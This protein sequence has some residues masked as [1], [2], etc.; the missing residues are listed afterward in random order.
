MQA[1]P[2]KEKR[3][4]RQ[5]HRYDSISLSGDKSG[6]SNR[7]MGT[8]ECLFVLLSFSLKMV[9]CAFTE[10]LLS[11]V[12][13]LSQ[14]I[15][16]MQQRMLELKKTLQK[17]LVSVLPSLLPVPSGVLWDPLLLDDASLSPPSH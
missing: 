9:K 17:E 14:A 5:V 6:T 4:W 7:C 3:P 12:G 15:K 16:Q 11:G 10:R 13:D 1:A 2:C 8:Q